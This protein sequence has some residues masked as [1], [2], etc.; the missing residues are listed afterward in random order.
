M[1]PVRTWI[2]IADGAR[3]RIVMNDGP[4]HGIKAVKGM[5][6]RIEHKPANGNLI[7]DPHHHFHS[8]AAGFQ[9]MEFDTETHLDEKHLFAGE[10]ASVLEGEMYKK[11]F[12]RMII[13]AAPAMLGELRTSLSPHLMNKVIEQVPKDLTHIPNKQLSRHIENVLAI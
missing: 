10:L 9:I 2:L 4:N 12:D 3:A 13:F 8:T 11:S 7:E 6:F 1:K 5:D